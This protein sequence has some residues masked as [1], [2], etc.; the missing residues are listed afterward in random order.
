MGVNIT[1]LRKDRVTDILLTFLFPDRN[2]SVGQSG[3]IIGMEMRDS[4]ERNQKG[5]TE[6]MIKWR[7]VTEVWRFMT[8][9]RSYNSSRCLEKIV[10]SERE[11]G[12]L[13]L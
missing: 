2:I 5:F 8:C 11:L 3:M 10:G 7:E 4:G 12:S 6:K 13:Q 1:F 9:D